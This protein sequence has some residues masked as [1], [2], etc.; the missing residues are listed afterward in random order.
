M[1]VKVER[2]SIFGSRR[3]VEG[4][5]DLTPPLVYLILYLLTDVNPFGSGDSKKPMDQVL[6][7]IC[8]VNSCK[9]L[10]KKVLTLIYM[11]VY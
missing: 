9:N 10:K 1:I 3:L 2:F 5:L 8:S 4:F 6:I 11:E 7:Q